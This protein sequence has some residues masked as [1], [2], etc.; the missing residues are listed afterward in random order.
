MAT[1]TAVGATVAV[2]DGGTILNAGTPASS[3]W[4]SLSLDTNTHPSALYGSRGVESNAWLTRVITAGK[5]ATMEVGQ[6]VGKVIGTRIA[7]TDDTY[8]RSGASETSGRTSLHYSRGYR[9][10]DI[11][12][13]DY[14]TGVATKGGNEGVLVQSIDPGT[15]SAQTHEPFPTDAVPGELVY[16]DGSLTPNQDD[17]KVRT[18]P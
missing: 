1:T 13:W 2:N 15:G 4:S 7:Q 10:H 11:T 9:R 18:N 8:L 14:A 16:M 5:Y 3:R 6:F 17:Y 12:S